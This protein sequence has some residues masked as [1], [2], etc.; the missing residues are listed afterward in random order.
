MSDITS[1]LKTSMV[2]IITA[3]AALLMM[4]FEGKRSAKNQQ[5]K[6]EL[7]SVKKARRIEKR[8]RDLSRDDL[9]DGL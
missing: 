3:V 8:N 9:I 5:T 4:F 1:I 7:E 6:E 2:F